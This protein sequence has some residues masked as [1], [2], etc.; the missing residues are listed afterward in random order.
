MSLTSL[1]S[2]TSLIGVEQS[3]WRYEVSHKNFWGA[4]L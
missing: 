1:N 3:Q 4:F 2:L